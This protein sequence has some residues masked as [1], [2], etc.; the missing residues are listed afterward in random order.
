MKKALKTSRIYSQKERGEKLKNIKWILI[1]SWLSWD[2]QDI[3]LL[4]Q[5]D[6]K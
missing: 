4:S 5:K 6:A 1:L 2:T 3:F